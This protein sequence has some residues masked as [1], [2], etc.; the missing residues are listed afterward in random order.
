MLTHS[1]HALPFVPEALRLTADTIVL[2]VLL[3]C[4]SHEASYARVV[5]NEYESGSVTMVESV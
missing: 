4:C 5:P 2:F 1:C 3:N